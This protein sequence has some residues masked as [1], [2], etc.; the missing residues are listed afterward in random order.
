MQTTF[1]HPLCNVLLLLWLWN[2]PWHQGTAAAPTSHSWPISISFPLPQP[3]HMS[4]AYY[5][6]Y[7]LEFPA[8][9]VI[10]SSLQKNAVITMLNQT[11]RLAQITPR[12]P[13]PGP[14]GGRRGLVQPSGARVGTRASAAPCGTGTPARRGH[15]GTKRQV[16]GKPSIQLSPGKRARQKRWGT[17]PPHEASFLTWGRKMDSWENLHRRSYLVKSEDFDEKIKNKWTFLF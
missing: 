2:G 6:L 12:L 17:C 5:I 7:L 14:L 11:R 1:L 15:L 9:L 3:C 16:L 8:R 13:H 10:T 4:G